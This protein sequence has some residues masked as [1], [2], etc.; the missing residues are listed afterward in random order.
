MKT[1]T[2]ILTEET[3]STIGTYEA[4]PDIITKDLGFEMQFG[5][6]H[7]ETV[8]KENR[9]NFNSVVSVPFDLQK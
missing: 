7:K 6:D 5:F 3:E 1:T 8:H 9:H 4:L 2:S